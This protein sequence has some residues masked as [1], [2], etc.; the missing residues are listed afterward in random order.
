MNRVENIH[1]TLS[2]VIDPK[3]NKNMRWVEDLTR[4]TILDFSNR[5]CIVEEKGNI[6]NKK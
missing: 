6:Q 3:E 1:V 4:E 5:E 2:H